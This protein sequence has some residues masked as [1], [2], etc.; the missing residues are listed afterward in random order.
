MLIIN[1]AVML[2]YLYLCYFVNCVCLVDVVV[3]QKQPDPGVSHLKFQQTE[4]YA[5]CVVWRHATA[6]PLL[7]HGI[8]RLFPP[9]LTSYGGHTTSYH[10]HVAAFRET[11]W[12]LIV[13][14]M[15]IFT[16]ISIDISRARPHGKP[17]H[18][19]HGETR[20][21]SRQSP[22]HSVWQTTCTDTSRY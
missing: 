16:E 12:R 1:R 8:P 18:S 22:S 13:P 14:A 19:A 21:S 3:V 17:R 15:A 2:L 10:G 20:A 4:R 5:L 9:H 6:V 11:P 7:R